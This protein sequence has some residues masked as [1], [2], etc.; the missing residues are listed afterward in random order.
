[1]P[2][3]GEPSKS[4]KNALK[5]WCKVRIIKPTP[6]ESFHRAT[7][8]LTWCCDIPECSKYYSTYRSLQRHRKEC[9]EPPGHR[10][11]CGLT[12]KRLEYLIGHE[13]KCRRKEI[14]TQTEPISDQS[15]TTQ[16]D[17]G[18]SPKSPVH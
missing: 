2:R 10:C 11:R 8:R 14:G 4:A 6:V 16:T 9:H 13:L 17:F 3:E 5:E 15:V 12:F 18:F 7:A 1:M